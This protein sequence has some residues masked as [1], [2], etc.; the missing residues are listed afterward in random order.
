MISG[1]LVSVGKLEV[2]DKWCTSLGRQ[3]GAR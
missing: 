1:A 3:A 2:A